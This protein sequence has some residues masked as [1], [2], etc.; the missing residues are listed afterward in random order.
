MGCVRLRTAGECRETIIPL[1]DDDLADAEE[2][3]MPLPETVPLLHAP[4]RTSETSTVS[5]L[6]RSPPSGVADH[7]D[8]H[9]ALRLAEESVAHDDSGQPYPLSVPIAKLAKLGTG[10]SLYLFFVYYAVCT[11][12]HGHARR[13][14]AAL[15]LCARDVQLMTLAQ[16]LALGVMSIITLPV[17]IRNFNGIYAFDPAENIHFPNNLIVATSLG[18]R[19]PH[20]PVHLHSIMDF[21]CTLAFLGFLVFYRRRQV[22]S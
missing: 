4:L 16:G 3:G 12:A 10:V 20:K 17:M 5:P 9:A 6:H 2:G 14:H 22:C 18:N 13:A 8:V 15:W 11:R 7:L 19:P 1:N 21:L